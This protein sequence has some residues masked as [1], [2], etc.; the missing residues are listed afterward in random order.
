MSVQRV[1]KNKRE[2]LTW[3]HF[4]V[5]LF[6]LITVLPMCVCIAFAALA[7]FGDRTLGK[8]RRWANPVT[9]SRWSINRAD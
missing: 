2:P 9:S 4:A 8:L 7:D 1:W 3:R 5:A 6:W